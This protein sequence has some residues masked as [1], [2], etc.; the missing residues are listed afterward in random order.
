MK[1]DSDQIGDGDKGEDDPRSQV[2]R[3]MYKR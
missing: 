3:V 1:H 2:A